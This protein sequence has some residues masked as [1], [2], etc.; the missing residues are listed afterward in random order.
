MSSMSPAHQQLLL[1]ALRYPK[2]EN[3]QTEDFKDFRSLIVWLEHTKARLEYIQLTASLLRQLQLVLMRVAFRCRYGIM[4]QET[5]R[6]F[7]I[8]RQNS[9]QLHTKRYT[10]ARQ[11]Q[12]TNT[13]QKLY[14]PAVWRIYGGLLHAVP[15]QPG[16]PIGPRRGISKQ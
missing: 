11:T 8:Q 1:R 15:D 3:V 5:E 16:V 10:A 12:R 6:N 14:S 13:L 9:G 7:R 2:H 4:L